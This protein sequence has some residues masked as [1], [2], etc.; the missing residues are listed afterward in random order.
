VYFFTEQDQGAFELL[1]LD[2]LTT[3][4]FLN[5]SANFLETIE[6]LLRIER[7]NQSDTEFFLRG[8]KIVG[9]AGDSNS[10]PTD[11]KRIEIRLLK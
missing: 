2:T 10:R 4:L 6:N 3:F 9:S 1:L 8:K 7:A 5:H 11:L